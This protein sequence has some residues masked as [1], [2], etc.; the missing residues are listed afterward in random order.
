MK[1]RPLLLLLLLPLL[2]MTKCEQD[3]APVFTLPPATQT[4][5]NTL[6]FV[7][8][9]RVWQNYGKMPYSASVSDNLRADYTTHG[10][11]FYLYAGQTALNVR[12]LFSLGLDSLTSI[13]V[14]QTTNKPVPNT[15]PRALRA[16]SFSDEL[17]HSSYGSPVKGAK[18][19]ITITKLDTIQH[20]VAGTFIGTLK[21][22]ND[23]TKLVHITD[24]RFDVHY[25]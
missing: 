5:A 7:I 12:E 1:I 4:G 18:G 17:T 2:G 24:G 22:A 6:G 8:D 25:Q 23:T 13:G 9:G 21:N 3:P 15:N 16:L 11:S 19:T 14:Y 10:K 20:I